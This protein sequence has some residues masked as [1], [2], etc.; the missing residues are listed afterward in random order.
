MLHAMAYNGNDG[1]QLFTNLIPLSP[2]LPQ[3]YNC[4]G[5]MPTDFFIRFAL[6][7]GCPPGQQES[8]LRHVGIRTGYRL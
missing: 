2:Y 8:A 3:Q 4:N 6:A 1:D 7:V 5:Q